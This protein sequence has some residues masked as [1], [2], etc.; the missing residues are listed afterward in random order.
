MN[1]IPNIKALGPVV[2]VNTFLKNAD[3]SVCS[4]WFIAAA[5]RLISYR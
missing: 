3:Q 5:G 4:N 1:E 2:P